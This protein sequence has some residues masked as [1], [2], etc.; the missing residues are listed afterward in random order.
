MWDCLYIVLN[1]FELFFLSD[2]SRVSAQEMDVTQIFFSGDPVLIEL[3][4]YMR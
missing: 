1:F 4:L 2:F 3:E